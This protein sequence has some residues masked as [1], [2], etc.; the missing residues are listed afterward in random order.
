MKL[1]ADIELK[2]RRFFRKYGKI[3][4]VIGVIVAIIIGVDR[5]LKLRMKNE[6]PQTTYN[7][8]ISVLDSSD[9]VPNKVQKSFEDFIDEYINYCNNQEY[10]SAYSMISEDC[11]ND[12]FG[13][14]SDFKSYVKNKFTSKKN[15]AIQSY[16]IYN[17]KYIYTVKLFDDFLATGLT[18]NSYR[19][20]EEKIV[21]SYDDK[22]NLV[23]SVGNFIEKNSIESVQENQY[24][25]VDVKNQ[26]IQYDYEQYSIKLTNKS[27]YYIIIQNGEAE[28]KEI[29]INLGQEYRPNENSDE[30]ILKP[31]EAITIKPVFQKFWDDKDETK[32]IVFS[33]V[34][35]VEPIDDENYNTIDKMSMT[36]GF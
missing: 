30:I 27:E 24:L 26:V 31:G 13:S 18:G 16:S 4:I 5:L 33:S 6:K 8:Q 7:P 28:D 12:Y 35:I 36:M 11:K 2:L 25:K 20:Q 32:A 1:K 14:L 10:D 17:K 22:H 21:A 3:L 34:R 15:Y 19:Y 29:Q 9:K 23:F